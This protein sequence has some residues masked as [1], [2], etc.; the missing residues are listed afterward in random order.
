MP[1]KFTSTP[2]RQALK[3]CVDTPPSKS[4]MH[5]CDYAGC[6]RSFGRLEHLKRHIRSHTGERPFPCTFPTC[7]K[8]FSRYDNMLQHA[9]CHTEKV[10]KK[11]K[12]QTLA[13]HTQ[14]PA[15]TIKKHRHH[16]PLLASI[17]QQVHVQASSVG[18][19]LGRPPLLSNHASAVP[20]TLR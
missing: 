14:M 20:C 19:K 9:R 13:N 3:Y 8:R 7:G 5:V 18:P 15:H 12:H 2:D 16:E 6:S 17:T 4:N 1:V 10:A 11:S